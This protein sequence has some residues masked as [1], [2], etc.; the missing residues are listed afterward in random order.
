MLQVVDQR[1]SKFIFSDFEASQDEIG[2]YSLGF[3]PKR[4][5]ETPLSP[6]DCH[7]CQNCA[8]CGQ[9]RHVLNF[10]VAQTVRDSCL[11]EGQTERSICDKCGTRS[12]KCD[13]VDKERKIFFETSMP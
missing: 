5:C 8:W 6:S 1:E 12:K 10:V 11:E 9:S 3:Y 4:C 13:T 7:T 2:Q